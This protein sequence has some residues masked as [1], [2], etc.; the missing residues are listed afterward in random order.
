MVTILHQRELVKW[1]VE[2]EDNL[3]FFVE[4]WGDEYLTFAIRETVNFL[5]HN[6]TSRLLKHPDVTLEIKLKMRIKED[7]Y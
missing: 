2:Y 7:D 4:L 3:F 1:D 6:E 5:E